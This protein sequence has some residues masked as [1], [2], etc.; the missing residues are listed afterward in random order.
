MLTIFSQS[1]E[2]SVGKSAT[3]SSLTSIEFLADSGNMVELKM[4]NPNF[5]PTFGPFCQ[6]LDRPKF[7]VELLF[8]LGW[9]LSYRVQG[10]IPEYKFS[11]Q[12]DK[13]C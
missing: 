3:F 2:V 9:N 13:A 1:I 8:F 5:D 6:I 10:L 7:S 4:K 12:E 11:A